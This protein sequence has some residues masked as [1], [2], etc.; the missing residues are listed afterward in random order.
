[1]LGLLVLSSPTPYL[2]IVC[3]LSEEI[4]TAVPP[5][6]AAREPAIKRMAWTESTTPRVTSPA[7]NLL[8]S[9]RWGADGRLG[10][11][12]TA[13][14]LPITR[15]GWER[16]AAPQ[17]SPSSTSRLPV[18]ELDVSTCNR[19]SASPNDVGSVYSSSTWLRPSTS[20]SAVS[21]TRSRIGERTKW[22]RRGQQGARQERHRA[23]F[24]I[25]KPYFMHVSTSYFVTCLL[26]IRGLK[27]WMSQLSLHSTLVHLMHKD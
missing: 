10:G 7:A 26:R 18:L 12:P 23:G 17:Q 22:M 20:T 1:M 15:R 2:S 25:L 16:A 4:A 8:V 27:I 5:S 13:A 11:S 6:F 21:P 24:F 14:G 3:D 19:L 9:V